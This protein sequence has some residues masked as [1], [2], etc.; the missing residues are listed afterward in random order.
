MKSRVMRYKDVPSK[1]KWGFASASVLVF[2][3]WGLYGATGRDDAHITYWPAH[4]LAHMGEI[5]NY[6]G[7]AV[8][9][10]SSLLQVV[11]L[12]ITHGV[13]GID[14]VTLGHVSS[15]VFGAA[16]LPLTYV[17]AR[18]LHPAAGP[19][20]TMM[21]A[22]CGSFV[23]W[24]FSGLEATLAAFC[25]LWC[26]LAFDDL[27][28][29]SVVSTWAWGH[30]AAAVLALITVRPEMP[31]VLG[32]IL[33]GS[34]AVLIWTDART[35]QKQRLGALLGLS[36]LLVGGL[37]LGR[38]LAFGRIV[39][40]PVVA[41]ASSLSVG[42]T[43]SGLHYFYEMLLRPGGLRVGITPLGLLVIIGGVASV[44]VLFRQFLLPDER[45]DETRRIATLL[46]GSFLL[47]YL[48]FIVL[49]G[50]DW[51]KAGRFTVP[52]VP[53]VSAF[54]AAGS[55]LLITESKM[56]TGVFVVT[57]MIS[58]LSA[59]NISITRSTG[60]SVFDRAEYERT[61]AAGL[62]DMAPLSWF[63]VHKRIHAKDAPLAEKIGRIVEVL[64]RRD[65][66]IVVLSEQA[67]MVF[68]KLARTYKNIEF[69]DLRG[70]TT[71]QL[72]GCGVAGGTYGLHFRQK[73]E[74]A[75]EC[76]AQEVDIIYGLGEIRRQKL[77]SGFEVVYRQKGDLRMQG[78]MFP[79]EKARGHQYVAVQRELVHEYDLST[80]THVW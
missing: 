44:G 5:V 21:T 26:L 58:L 11:V 19:P 20:A 67:G 68:Y 76:S 35:S 39:P 63:E 49:A 72:H 53:I 22:V 52:V 45:E 60:V 32:C 55:A 7:Q 16:S 70:L 10:S 12:A 38:Y 31:I 15:I 57:V 71:T 62:K 2:V 42:R 8:E 64:R 75:V 1:V 6:N 3:G 74:S 28:R 56:R 46:G 77:A 14:I 79:G 43:L 80:E 24:S 73:Y 27:L 13:S 54:V 23:Y 51:M 48:S 41:K 78:S 34:G 47:A 69:V 61:L 50:G 40:L 17:F 18:R 9:Q 36:A 65:E 33:A 4:T 30:A 59:I 66:N 25:V 37:L 29:A